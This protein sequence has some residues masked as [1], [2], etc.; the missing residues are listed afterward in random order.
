MPACCAGD[1]E[2]TARNSPS[3]PV[4]RIITISSV[5]SRTIPCSSAFGSTLAAPFGLKVPAFLVAR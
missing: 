5:P 3:G 2:P 4:T 1:P